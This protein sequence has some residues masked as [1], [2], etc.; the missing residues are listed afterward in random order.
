M[1]RA[2]F[3]NDLDEYLYAPAFEDDEDHD[4]IGWAGDTIRCRMPSLA[5]G[6]DN[7]VS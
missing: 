4:R 3:A 1:T 2:G 6:V 7:V 5:T